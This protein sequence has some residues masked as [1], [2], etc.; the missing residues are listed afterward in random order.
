MS[1]I[2]VTQIKNYLN[3]VY[4]GLIDLSDCNPDE[5]ANFFLTRALTAYTIQNLA[6][7][8]PSTASKFV[9]DGSNDN[10][11]DGIFYD[12]KMK[13]LYIVQSKWI[14][15]GTGEPENGDIKNSSQG[16]ET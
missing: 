11:I 14:S 16:Q 5:N 9:V 4:N 1:I 13:I 12:E 2:H 7:V 15:N 3:S 8:D 10:G 6:Q